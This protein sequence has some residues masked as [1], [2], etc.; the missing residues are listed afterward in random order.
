[1]PLSEGKQG[2]QEVQD[3]PQRGKRG[4]ELLLVL[5]LLHGVND[6]ERPTRHEHALDEPS[7]RD[8]DREQPFRQEPLLFGQQVA[9]ADEHD[10]RPVD[11]QEHRQG[12]HRVKPDAKRQE[13]KH[14]AGHLD[15]LAPVDVLEVEHGEHAAREKAHGVQDGNGTR[16]PHHV[17]ADG[18]R[19]DV[20]RKPR[21]RLYRIGNKERCCEKHFLHVC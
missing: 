21:D 8:D 17:R 9:D 12:Q 3:G 10:D 11:A 7:R 19:E 15:E 20:P 1:M 16:K 14:A 4:A 2:I 6:E 13:G 5:H 18:H